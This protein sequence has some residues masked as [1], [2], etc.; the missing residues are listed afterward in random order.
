LDSRAKN[1]SSSEFRVL[2][3]N[4]RGA[5]NKAFVVVGTKSKADL[6]RIGEIVIVTRPEDPMQAKYPFFTADSF[7]RAADAIWQNVQLREMIMQDDLDFL[8]R[9]S[10]QMLLNWSEFQTASSALAMYFIK[11]KFARLLNARTA[12]R[13]EVGKQLKTYSQFRDSRGRPNPLITSTIFGAAGRKLKK[14]QEFDSRVRASIENW[15]KLANSLSQSIERDIHQLFWLLT[16]HSNQSIARNWPKFLRRLWIKPTIYACLFADKL[17]NEEGLN[18]QTSKMIISAF[19]IELSL[20]DLSAA[21]SVIRDHPKQFDQKSYQLLE[22]TTSKPGIG[23]CY[24]N[25]HSSISSLL[26]DIASSYAGGDFI[27]G[28]KKIVKA[29]RLIRYRYSDSDDSPWSY[30]RALATP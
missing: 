24:D 6:K 8:D 25:L 2:K 9:T 14:Q 13:I 15:G 23:E 26:A 21:L 1:V 27:S 12:R 11:Q 19:L 17:K 20:M 5:N 4:E 3:I 22:F 29:K 30:L 16:Y 7:I 10:R 18:E 28:K